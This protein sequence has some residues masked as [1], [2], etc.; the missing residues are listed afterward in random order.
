VIIKTLRDLNVVIKISWLV[1]CL[2]LVAGCALDMRE[3]PRYEAFEKSTFFGD[4]LSARPRVADTI[5]HDQLRI[6][7]HLY[8]GQING[9]FAPTFPFTVT[10]EVLQ[11]GQERFNIFCTP[12]HGR[13]GD[14][15][16][17]MVEYGLEAP[18]S[19]HSQDMR[20][21]APG[22]YFDI[23]TRG[24]RVMPSYASRIPPEDRWAIIAYIRALQLS[25]NADLSNVPP[26]EVPN[27]DETDVITQ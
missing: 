24:T 10:L 11:R 12:C 18:P 17:I 27:L 15:Q 19:F 22:Y 14:G 2:G 21:Q 8:T 13:V 9:E 7:Q 5:A 6:D 1:I 23:I 4:N 26:Q 16:S 3:Q 20:G 25:Q